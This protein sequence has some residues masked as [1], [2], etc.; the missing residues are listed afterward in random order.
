VKGRLPDPTKRGARDDTYYATWAAHYVRLAGVSSA[1]VAELA[2]KFGVTR[3]HA[4]FVDAH[5]PAVF[6]TDATGPCYH[7]AQDEIGIVDFWKLRF[8]AKSG[9]DTVA[10]LIDGDRPTFVGSRPVATFA[11]AVV[12]AQLMNTGVVDFGRFSAEQQ[13]VLVQFRDDLNAIVAAEA[14]N[15]GPDDVSTMLIG[16]VNLVSILETGTC[17]G[18]LKGPA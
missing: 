6:F 14:D 18:F 5:V 16:A 8:E 7:T 10:G 2:E 3:D 4:T 13:A 17:D 15:F 12:I 9:L 11:D 1:P